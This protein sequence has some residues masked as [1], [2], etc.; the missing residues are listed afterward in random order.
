MFRFSSHVHSFSG[1]RHFAVSVALLCSFSTYAQLVPSKKAVLINRLPA[2]Y[3]PDDDVIVKPVDNELSF[4]QQYV[5][6][7][8][9]QEVLRARN[10]LKIWSDNQVFADQYGVNTDAG[11]AFYVP[12]QQ[13]KWIYFQERYLRYLRSR[14][15]QPLKQL[16]QTWY[17]E[18]RASNEVDTIDEIEGRF[19][20]KNGKKQ[21]VALPEAFQ[22]KKISLWKKTNFIFQP[23]LDQG[24]VVVGFKGPIAHARAWVGV[25]GKAE[26]NIQ[27]NVDS[28]GLRG[29]WNYYTDTGRYFTS[30]DKSL[31]DHLSARLTS[32]R[33]A[34]G[35]T[36]NTLML[37]YTKQF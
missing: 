2:N 8:K 16:P 26:I 1:L 4:Y 21:K 27:K 28:I 22:E 11:S 24:I 31:T 5:A 36:D 19:K 30:L 3:I 33:D 12:T 7:D 20:S 29:M 14:G 13:E 35:N 10:Q 25:N 32:I 18:Y 17:Q 15:E 9:S 37:L 6:S 23:R 34:K